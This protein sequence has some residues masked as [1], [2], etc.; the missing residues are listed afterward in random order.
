[1]G[2]AK[3]LGSSLKLIVEPIINPKQPGDGHG[4]KAKNKIG[5]SLVS[6]RIPAFSRSEAFWI[7]VDSAPEFLDNPVIGCSG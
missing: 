5:F 7:L 4:K 3:A 2:A 1:M 6:D